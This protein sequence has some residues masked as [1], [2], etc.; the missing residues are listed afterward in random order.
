MVKS[1]SYILEIRYP[2]HSYFSPLGNKVIH[3]ARCVV[4]VQLK[5]QLEAFVPRDRLTLMCE[6][7]VA[8]RGVESY[9]RSGDFSYSVS[10]M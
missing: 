7:W 4:H 1:V 3:A 8:Y 5:K 2:S 6:N 9:V 10:R